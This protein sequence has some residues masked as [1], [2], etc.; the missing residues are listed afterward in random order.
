MIYAT[1]DLHLPIGLYRYFL[2]SL[3][4]IK[5]LDIFI[6]AGDII[7][8]GRYLFLKKVENDLK[9][10]QCPK[11]MVRGNN[12]FTYEDT[13]K[14]LNEIKVLEDERIDLE[15]KGRKIAIIGTLG[16]LD[17]PT[18]WQRKNIPNIEEI[19]MER[20]EK[21]KQLSKKPADIK[22]LVSHY[23]VTFL[24]TPKDPKPVWP[25][26]GS[27]KWFEILNEFDVVI[28]GHI[29]YGKV[30]SIYGKTRIYNVSLY[31]NKKIVRIEI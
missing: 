5:E 16:I 17:R 24:N 8:R 2:E 4:E 19:Y 10:I 31:Q 25:E 3:K 13:I 9:K 11:F 15:I 23:A 21:I 22:I 26:L 14:Y 1:A 30:F 12:E 29:H 7:D 18:K 27:E 20:F 28:H 6:I